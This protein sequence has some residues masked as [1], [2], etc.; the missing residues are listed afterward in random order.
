MELNDPTW[1]ELKQLHKALALEI[2][3]DVPYSKT[4]ARITL[5]AQAK[6]FGQ[7]CRPTS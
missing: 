6:E 4:A 1:A 3:K 2:K 5:E 7:S